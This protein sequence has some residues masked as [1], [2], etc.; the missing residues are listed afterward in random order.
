M[1]SNGKVVEMRKVYQIKITLK[2]IKPP[3]WRRL[4]VT[5]DTVLEKLH[6]IIQIA[7][8]WDN[9]HL[10]QFIDGDT[11]YVQPDSDYDDVMKSENGVAIS[12]LVSGEGARFH[13]EY[14]FGDG[15]VHEILVEK[16]LPVEKGKQYPVCIKGKRACPP[17]DVGGVWGYSDFLETIM[18]PKDPEYDNMLEW[19]GGDFDPEVFDM[20]EV[21]K[22]LND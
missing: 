6:E 22:R 5:N 3:I 1:N 13:Y 9:Y 21:N 19:V 14:D 10:H 16:I 4:Q 17:E 12:Q 2:D 8:G 11:Y 18:N 15:W 20:D 7:M